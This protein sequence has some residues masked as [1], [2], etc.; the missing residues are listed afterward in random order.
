VIV[1]VEFGALSA[2]LALFAFEWTQH[3]RATTIA[4]GGAE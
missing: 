3:A 4:S 2:D 1:L